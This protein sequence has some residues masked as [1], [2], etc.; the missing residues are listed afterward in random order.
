M[1]REIL[2]TVQH[3]TYAAAA[4]ALT[5]GLER[6]AALN[7]NVGIVITDATGEI[8]TAARTDGANPRAW[9]GGLGKAVAAAGIGRSTEEFIDKRL[10]SDEVLWRAMSANPDSF[11]VPGGV[12]F[13]ANGRAVGAVG[14]SGGHY[15]QDAE[16]AQAVADKFAELLAAAGEQA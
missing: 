12:A 11:W 7:I 9:K 5:A 1:S 2:R 13:V 8:V 16:V 3:V 14:V 15:K 4:Q 6:A 10:K